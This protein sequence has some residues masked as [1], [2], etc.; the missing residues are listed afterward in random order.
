[1]TSRPRREDEREGVDYYFISKEAFEEEI[2]NGGFL[3]W[4]EN[5]GNLYGTP[6]EFI[7]KV[8]SE[9]KN[10]LLSI[11]VKGAMNIRKRYPDRA[12]L[13][14]ILPP[15]IGALEER[16]K[17]RKTDDSYIISSRLKI[18]RDE[19]AYKDRYDH[20]VI[21]DNLNRAYQKLKKIILEEEEARV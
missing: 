13:I 21:N 6:K 16:L 12:V 14:F 1:V 15:S 4:E 3:E 7:E 10:V 11:D 9:G 18:A 20:S 19:M 2:N 5:F 8:I 17:K